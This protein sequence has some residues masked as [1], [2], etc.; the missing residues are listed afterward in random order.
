MVWPCTNFSRFIVTEA[1]FKRTDLESSIGRCRMTKADQRDVMQRCP[2]PA[3]G[4]LQAFRW[5]KEGA[6]GSRPWAAG[7]RGKRDHPPRGK[8]TYSQ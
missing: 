4:P 7:R 5:G 1:E 8:T 6:G 2:K 3:A